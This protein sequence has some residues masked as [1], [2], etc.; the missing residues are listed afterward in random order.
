MLRTKSRGAGDKLEQGRM[1]RKTKKA[2]R[3]VLG[4][5]C[6]DAPMVWHR[7]RKWRHLQPEDKRLQRVM[8]FLWGTWGYY[9]LAQYIN[10]QFPSCDNE[11]LVC[12]VAEEIGHKHLCGN[13]YGD[14]C[15]AKELERLL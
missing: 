4:R 3:L 8:K 13:G 11:E 10:K 2:G 9:E 7:E 1:G 12:E 14:G 5:R 6:C 15:I